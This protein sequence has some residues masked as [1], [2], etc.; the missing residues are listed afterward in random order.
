VFSFLAQ[1]S[2]R[3]KAIVAIALLVVVVLGVHAFV[4]E[5]YQTGISALHED[6]E[7]QNSDLAWMKSA[8]TRL[9]VASAMN[10]AGKQVIDGTLAN[11]IDQ[12]VRRQGLRQQ[13]SQIS[14][15]GNDEIRMRYKAVDFNRLVSFIAEVNT[16]GLLVKD[17]RILPSVNP[18][19]VDSN[20]VFVRR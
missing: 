19:I 15:I 6:I 17:M 10:S 11:F 3:E 9:P 2:M 5:P 12:V 18:G 8:I 1:Y 13:L 7:Q 4:I 16:K 20:I 14:P